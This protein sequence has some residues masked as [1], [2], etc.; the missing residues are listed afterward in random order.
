MPNLGAV[1]KAAIASLL[2]G[3]T[4]LYAAL[5]GPN[6]QVTD[7]E[8]V[9]IAIAVITAVAVYVVPNAPQSVDTAAAARARRNGPVL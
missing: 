7:Q 1:A 6:G 3:L 2:A 4:A 5:N 8:W 9:T